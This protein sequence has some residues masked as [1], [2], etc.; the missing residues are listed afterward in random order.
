VV[1][2]SSP[3]ELLEGHIDDAASNGVCWHTQSALATTLSH[4]W[5]LGTE[6]K[7]LGSGHSA[8]LIED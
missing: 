8:D 2:L 1:S 3:G 4:F 6:L 5:E 7:L